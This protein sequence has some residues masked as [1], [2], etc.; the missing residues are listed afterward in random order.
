MPEA[1]TDSSE[2]DD[3]CPR[4]WPRHQVDVPVR[5]IVLTS[6]KTQIFDARGTALSEGGMALFAG[7]EL[8]PGDRVAVEFTPAYAAPP[9]RVDATIC[10]R[11]G[12]NY[13]VEFL[14]GNEGQK[15][16][17]EQL[18]RHLPTLTA[19]AT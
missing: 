4:R 7:A 1:T 11:N 18:H 19:V 10:N 8:K 6:E 12:Y 17:V 3:T 13:G 15:E 14:I 5:I 9:I 2:H 16:R